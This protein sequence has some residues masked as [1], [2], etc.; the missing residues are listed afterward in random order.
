[1]K[2]IHAIQ[3]KDEDFETTTA[4]TPAEIKQLGSA[5]WVKYYEMNGIRF[6]KKPKSWGLQ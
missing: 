3:F 5:G 1:M 2:Y 6:H 4:T